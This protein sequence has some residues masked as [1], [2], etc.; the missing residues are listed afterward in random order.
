M[1]NIILLSDSYKAS[2]HRQYP[3]NTSLVFSYFESRGGKFESVLFFGLQYILK[4]YFEGPVVTRAKIDQAE[5]FFSLHFGDSGHF[6]KAGWEHILNHHGGFLPVSIKA[7]AEGSVVPNHNV[8]F[9]IENTDPACF[10]LP[11]FLE[12]LLV[13]VWY[14]CTVATNSKHQKLRIIEYMHKSG[15]V[16][17][18]S[19]DYKLHDFGFRGVSSVES[20]AIGG[21]AHLV[22]FKGTDTLSAIS[23]GAEYYDCPMAGFSIPASEHSTITSWGRDCELDAFRNMLQQYP[24]G[25]VA[26]V[27]DS[28]DIFRAT[29]DFWGKEL[30]DLIMNRNG[31]LVIRPDSGYPPEVVLKVLELLGGEKGGFEKFITRTKTGHKLLPPQIRVIQGDAVD[32]EMIANVYD[33]VLAGGWAADNVSFGSGGALLQKINRDTLKFALKCCA[34][35]VNGCEREVYKDP[36]TDPGKK[37]K[38]GRLTLVKRDGRF[39]TVKESETLLG[40]AIAL[41]EVFRNGKVLVQHSLDDIRARAF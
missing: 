26:C 12:T 24:N 8:L 37:S 25:P 19:A 41:R 1:D 9:T 6:N 20:S 13:E 14:P 29:K 4:R 38:K 31:C 35:V 15:C 21:L 11:N 7:V 39:V 17:I 16:N 3:P 36:V 30:R 28:W 2:H 32:Y 5:A 23:C 22:C 18:S 40:D 10:W 27:S 34:V 33:A